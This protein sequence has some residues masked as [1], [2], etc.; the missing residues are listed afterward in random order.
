MDEIYDQ[1]C[2]MCGTQNVYTKEQAE[3]FSK[4]YLH[5]FSDE[6]FEEMSLLFEVVNFHEGKAKYNYSG[7]N[8]NDRANQS[9]DDWQDIYRRIKSHLK[10]YE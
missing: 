10:K 5:S 7:L 9:F 6:V 1:H 2:P 3:H 8:D 4:N